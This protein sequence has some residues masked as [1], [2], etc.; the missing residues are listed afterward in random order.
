M[1][2]TYFDTTDHEESLV[3]VIAS[4]IPNAKP[5][6]LM[7]PRKATFYHP[8][9]YPKATTIVGSSLSKLR[10][11]SPFAKFLAMWL[12]VIT[13]IAKDTVRTLKR[14]ANLACNRCNAIN[15]R[16][17]LCD[18]MAVSA[19][20]FYRQRDAIG[21]RY[22]MMLRAFFAAI[23]GVWACF[24]PPKTARTEAESTTAREKSICSACRNL[25]NKTLWIL[26]HTPALCQSRR[27]RQQVMPE[28][29][30]ISKGRSSHAMPVL[31]TNR[32]PVRAS[33]SGT[34]LRPGYRNLRFFFGISG[35]MIC[36]SSSLSIG[37]AISSLLACLCNIRL[38]MLSAMNTRNTSFC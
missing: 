7:K 33:L 34:G 30:P 24:R 26:S 4:F 28:P 22:Q 15:Q 29:Q 21:V 36:H 2:P 37:F 18:I 16:Q 17:Q 31:S 20:Q 19:G 5:T 23:C 13:A 3:D 10:R 8:P 11:N 35:S 14:S 12:A 1:V 9:I 25:L 27:R 38:L 32:I 6:V